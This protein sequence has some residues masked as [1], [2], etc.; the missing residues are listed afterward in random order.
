MKNFILPGILIG[1]LIAFLAA[2]KRAMQ[3]LILNIIDIG[4]N[5]KKSNIR[6]LVFNVKIGANNQE[7][8]PVVIKRINLNLFANQSIIANFNRSVN[9]AVLP[10]EEKEFFIEI[11]LNNLSAVSTIITALATG[12]TPELTVKGTVL[13]DLGTITVE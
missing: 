5:S 13:T 10:N 8:L 12:Q 7:N 3:N 1:G 2:K 6:E 4:I 9:L 11:R